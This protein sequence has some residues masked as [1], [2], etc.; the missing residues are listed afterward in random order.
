MFTFVLFMTHHKKYACMKFSNYRQSRTMCVLWSIKY[1]TAVFSKCMHQWGMQLGKNTG[2][3]LKKT[4]NE[5]I[6]RF[7]Y[8]PSQLRCGRTS[9]QKRRRR[10][11]KS[12]SWTSERVRVLRLS[13]QL[14]SWQLT[15]FWISA[16]TE[17]R[18]S[19]SGGKQMW[20][21]GTHVIDEL[22]KRNTI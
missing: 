1:G 7:K 22:D 6:S 11:Y 5:K 15:E 3:Y 19:S 4:K 16:T 20:A 14:Q 21:R 2:G 12:C 10:S 17:L 18:N 9:H 13:A 8:P